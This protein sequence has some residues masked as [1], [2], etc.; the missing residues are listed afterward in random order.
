[1]AQINPPS[2]AHAPRRSSHKRKR[3][4]SAAP[5]SSFSVGEDRAINPLCYT[6]ATLRQL[7]VAGHS[8]ADLLPSTSVAQ[9]P[10]RPLPP[11]PLPAQ[12]RFSRP[13]SVAAAAAAADD[14]G[15]ETEGEGKDEGE[16]EN[17]SEDAETAAR[18]ARGRQQ[19]R[20]RGRR[21]VPRD[22]R[23]WP[24]GALRGLGP[25][26]GPAQGRVLGRRGR[27]PDAAG[28][29]R[30]RGKRKLVAANH[31]PRRW[32]RAANMPAVRDFFMALIHQYPYNKL[33]PRAVSALDF[34]PALLGCELYNAHAEHARALR[35]LEV[36]EAEEDEEEGNDDDDE[37]WSGGG[38]MD[39]G[40]DDYYHDGG[41]GGV[42]R[43]ADRA[44]RRRA[45]RDQLRREALRQMREVARS[46]DDLM[47]GP[48]YSASHELLRLRGMVALYMGD[49]AMPPPR[50][51]PPPGRGDDDDD[52]DDVELHEARTQRDTERER[53]RRMFSKLLEGGGEVE[54][55]IRD[56]VTRCGHDG[57]EDDDSSIINLGAL[58]SSLPIR[59]R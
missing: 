56:F 15:W 5:S 35:R 59:G 22:A 18:A 34:W 55:W 44:E 52:D 11:S 42:R 36:A 51:P 43:A 33:H 58:S 41:G 46:M 6:P 47:V 26:C 29:G 57:E 50:S 19:P 3:S 38:P 28:R 2:F 49:L 16:G 25:A 54:D 37:G 27:D 14:D 31:R 32:G 53:A 48:P 40:D 8:D 21:P 17:E 12:S 45:A 20:A 13:P 24:A 1:M 7:Q 30:R 10:H 39:E 4:E 9:F 23:L